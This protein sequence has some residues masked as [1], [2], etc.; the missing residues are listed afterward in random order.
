MNK[1]GYIYILY[2]PIYKTYGDN[3]YKIGRSIDIYSR[4]KGF[5][6]SYIEPS[7]VKFSLFSKYFIKL[8]KRVHKNLNRYRINLKREYF[9]CDLD[10]IVKT[11][12]QENKLIEEEN[13]YINQESTKPT[14]YESNKQF[15]KNYEFKCEKCLK[16]FT[17]KRNLQSHGNVCKGHQILTPYKCL[18]CLK[19]YSSKQRLNTH[20]DTCK[21]KKEKDEQD[22][23]K[24]EIKEIVN[25]TFNKL[26]EKGL[27][28]K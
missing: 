12:E 28:N 10:L 7:T 15:T 22:K 18:F 3:V 17:C 16:N 13:E 14:S 19:T 24:N 11:I 5:T 8:E 9:N 27:L 26:V 23:K 21:K 2:N 4:L 6:T 25:T 20:L 1:E